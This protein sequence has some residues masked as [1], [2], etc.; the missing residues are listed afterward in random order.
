[1]SDRFYTQMLDATGWCP[2]YR[3]TFTLAEYKQKYKTRKRKMAWTDEL[4]AQA[5]EMYTA[6]EPTPET[7]MEIV[8]M[9]ADDIDESP[10][11]VRMI[12]T[13]AGVYVKKTP[14]TGTKSGST[15]GTRVS[16]AGAQETLTNAISDA[17]K[18][19]DAAIISKLTGKAAQ[20]FAQLI[21]E[22]ND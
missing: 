13:K 21:N 5:V 11:G 18:E 4:K 14:A 3:N 12:L 20:Y 6:E 22:L 15:G 7:S 8:K 17:G 16:V 1:M 2:G 9:I 19:P 10:N